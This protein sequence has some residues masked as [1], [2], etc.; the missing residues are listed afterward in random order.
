MTYLPHPDTEQIAFANVLTALGDETRLAIIGHLARNEENAM[1]CGQ[2][3]DLGSKTSLSYHLAKLREAGVVHVRPEGTKR[4]VTLR[5]ADLD[6]RFLG[7]LD[8][9]VATTR[10]LPFACRRGDVLSG[11]QA[12][13]ALARESAPQFLT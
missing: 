5:R 12:A 3:L 7:F 1:T 8:S 10:H 2:F 4:F 6:S 11:Q 9:I 13:E